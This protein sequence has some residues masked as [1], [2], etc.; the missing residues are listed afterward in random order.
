MTTKKRWIPEKGEQAMI[1]GIIEGSPDAIGVAVIRLDC[2]CRKMAAVDKD[3]EPASKVIMYRDHAESI[4]DICKKD[5]G[6]YRRVT[7]QFISWIS[8][9]PDQDT[10]NK[11]L[12]KVLGIQEQQP[13]LH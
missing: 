12:A 7:E 2:G 10:R 4:C 5:N 3:G 1:E 13:P 11:I 9:E 8:P 6:D